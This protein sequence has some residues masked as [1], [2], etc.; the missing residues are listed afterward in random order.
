MLWN[1]GRACG[2]GLGIL[3]IF[4]VQ[5][6]HVCC[7]WATQTY[8]PQM[9]NGNRYVGFPQQDG[10]LRRLD[11]SYSQDQIRQAFISPRVAH[12]SSLSTGTTV[13][14]GYSEGL[15]ASSYEQ[16]A[17]EPARNLVRLVQSSLMT[18]PNWYTNVKSV[19][20]QE[21]P[22]RSPFRLSAVAGRNSLNRLGENQNSLPD[23]RKEMTWPFQRG[24]LQ[25][26]KAGSSSSASLQTLTGSSSFKPASFQKPASAVVRGQTSASA[27]AKRVT[28]HK[29]EPLGISRDFAVHGFGETWLPVN[30]G[31]TQIGYMPSSTSNMMVS[32]KPSYTFTDQRPTSSNPQAPWGIRNPA[33]E[34]HSLPAYGSNTVGNLAQRFAPTRIYEVPE[35]F[36]GY[37]I[38]RL[39]DEEV[40][41]VPQTTT[42]PPQQ[43]EYLNPSKSEHPYAKWM[44]IKLRPRY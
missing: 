30:T 40:D 4:L 14:R 13:N 37:A 24:T 29:S 36:G 18:K 16:T 22:N 42:P 25:T 34:L 27:P 28:Q 38:R 11:G 20:S 21:V 5:A 7:S 12:S 39:G 10:R 3:L 6:E 44:R 2:A 32:Y 41:Q 17:S 33:Q 9:R 43:M 15:S 35:H 19:N 1:S 31:N 8:S 23:S 26:S